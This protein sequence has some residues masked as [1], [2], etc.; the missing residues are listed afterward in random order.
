VVASTTA[1]EH[2]SHRRGF[3]G[4]GSEGPPTLF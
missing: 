1:P 3:L 2:I 4:V